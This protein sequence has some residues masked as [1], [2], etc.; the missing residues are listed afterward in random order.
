MDTHSLP[1][2]HRGAGLAF[3]VFDLWQSWLVTCKNIEG[4][5]FC[6]FLFC[7]LTLLSRSD[8]AGMQTTPCY[9]MLGHSLQFI[10]PLEL[11]LVVKQAKSGQSTH[12][13]EF[14]DLENVRFSNI[15]IS[16]R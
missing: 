12:L 8:G 10:V 13:I 11:G 16:E 3:Q 7:L 15:P 9:S 2:V 1:Q 14:L 4:H 6:C 5:G